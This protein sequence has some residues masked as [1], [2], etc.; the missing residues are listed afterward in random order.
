MSRNARVGVIAAAV[1]VA[2]AGFVIASSSDDDESKPAKTADTAKTKPPSRK[3]A[4]AKPAPPTIEVK[5]GKPVGGVRKIEVDSGDRVQFRVE[6]DVAD[7]IHV[8]GYDL[9]KDVEAGG[10]VSFDFK[11]DDDGLYE[12]ELED[13]GEQIASLTVQP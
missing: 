3:P 4:E 8:H 9:M 13:R 7:E 5:N 1:A 10:S 11:A 6:S 12:V 2:V